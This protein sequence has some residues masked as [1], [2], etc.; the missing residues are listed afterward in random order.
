MRCNLNPTDPANPYYVAQVGDPGEAVG[1]SQQFAVL[2]KWQAPMHDM[3]AL[4][5][6]SRRCQSWLCMR[7]SL[8]KAQL[9]LTSFS[10]LL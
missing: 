8:K 10:Y 7:V 3:L 9:W 4:C 1:I 5:S 6:Q 2:A